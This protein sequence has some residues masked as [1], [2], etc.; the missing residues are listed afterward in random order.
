[1]KQEL[2]TTLPHYHIEDIKCYDVNDILYG[3][4]ISNRIKFQAWLVN[5]VV[6]VQPPHFFIPDPL[7]RKFL[8]DILPS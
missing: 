3:F 8:T 5:K 2:V 1:M 4:S 7:L 6:I